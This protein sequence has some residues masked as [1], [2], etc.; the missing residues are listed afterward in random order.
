MH[1]HVWPLLT[2]LTTRKPNI[3]DQ[4]L[5]T[6]YDLWSSD[7]ASW[8]SRAFRCCPTTTILVVIVQT[9]NVVAISIF[10][11]TLE[12]SFSHRVFHFATFYSPV[13]IST[14]YSP[15]MFFRALY[16]PAMFFFLRGHFSRSPARGRRLK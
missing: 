4:T 16:F 2:M 12:R 8:L 10:L 14:F 13:M 3:N 9:W 1:M 6:T 7:A 5:T 11:I 15:A